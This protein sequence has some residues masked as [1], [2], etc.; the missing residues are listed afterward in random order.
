MP[1]DVTSTDDGKQTA[2]VWGMVFPDD[3]D[4]D[5]EV[6][7]HK[8]D[9]SEMQ[10]AVGGYIELVGLWDMGGAQL[11]VNEEGRLTG[12]PVNTVATVLARRLD[13]IVGP[14]ILVGP[15]DDGGELTPLTVDMLLLAAAAITEAGDDTLLSDVTRKLAHREGSS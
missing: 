14:A 6:F 1:P 13:I 12:L 8:P 3:P 5:V 9:L 15:A 11:V 10:A 4:A 7:D 2:E